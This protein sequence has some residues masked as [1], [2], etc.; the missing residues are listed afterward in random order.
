MSS[1]QNAQ[2]LFNLRHAQARNVIERMF[3]VL[4]RRFRIL[5]LPTEYSLEVQAH[6]P[7][8]L[9][10][11]H[12]FIKRHDTGTQLHSEPVTGYYENEE[13]LQEDFIG[14]DEV[15]DLISTDEVEDV[16]MDESWVES[17]DRIAAE[18]WESYLRQQGEGG[19]SDID[20]GE[21]EEN[22]EDELDVE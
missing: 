10:A 3:G 1:P 11:L 20:E 9:A 13:I 15:E 7:A 22:I 19:C 12:N 21:N 14:T 18:M 8:A 6:I 17:R 2:E 5:Q 4:K 16:R